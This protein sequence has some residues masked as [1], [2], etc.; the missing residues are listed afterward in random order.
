MRDAFDDYI[1]TVPPPEFDLDAVAR[2]GRRIRRRRTA[3]ASGG[4][5]L[6]IGA[7]A[8]ALALLP[9][10]APSP[11][12][13]VTVA[14]ASA[15]AS[16]SP[17]A[18][19]D[20][21]LAALRDAVVREAPGVTGAETLQRYVLLCGLNAQGENLVPYTPQV[22]HSTCPGPRG[23]A[24]DVSRSYIWQG[25]ITG[26]RGVYDIRIYIRRTLYVDPSAP[27]LDETDAQERR[28]AEQQG[29]APR[30]GPNG[31]S[32]RVGSSSLDM[33][34]PDGTGIL[35]QVRNTDET[36]ANLTYSPFTADQLEAIG[37]DPRLHL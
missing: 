9:P 7:G 36:G 15:I 25:R 12:P 17:A 10:K 16:P 19:A 26:P 1:G 37:L 33:I 13:P 24:V 18:E 20:R 29:Y 3:Y 28:I 5:A 30:R 31:E 35:I 27:P 21:L 22:A 14:S 32:I 11:S 4:A 8:V 2:R 34:K 6:A 23:Q